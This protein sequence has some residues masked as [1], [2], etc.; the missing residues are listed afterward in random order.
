MD[1]FGQRA[2]RLR[3]NLIAAALYFCDCVC[4]TLT[5][6]KHPDAFPHA[7]IVGLLISLALVLGA[8]AFLFACVLVFFNSR[9]GYSLGLIAALIALPL[10]R[11][12]R[13]V[14]L[15]EFVDF[16]EWSVWNCARR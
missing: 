7:T 12:V 2:E 8:L 9:F 4:I 13:V 5:S 16:S 1:R 10:V 3:P 11:L 15:P 14:A 6:L